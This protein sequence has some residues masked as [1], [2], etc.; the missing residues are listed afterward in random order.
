MT[1]ALFLDRDG[2]IN[3]DTGYV[4]Q[5]RNFNFIDGIFS[6]VKSANSKGI[7]VIVVTN[8]A[9]IGRGYYSEEDF[10][11]LSHW[12]KRKFIENGAEIDGIYHCPYHPQHGL[13]RYKKD[14]SWRKPNPGMLIQASIDYS[15]NLSQSIMVGDKRSDIEAADAAGVK[16]LFLLS[17]I[18]HHPLA[19]NIQDLNQVEMFISATISDV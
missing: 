11:H 4:F 3:E 2:V 10:Q 12:M 15:L 9:G 5:P 14:S 1:I 18:E 7:K 6:L 17:D 19:I 8:Q 13:G 16:T